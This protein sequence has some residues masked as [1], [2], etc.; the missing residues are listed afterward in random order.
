MNQPFPTVQLSVK[1][2]VIDLRW[3]QPDPRLLPAADMQRATQLALGR[4][5]SESLMY[6]ADAGAGPLLSWLSNRIEQK[7]GRAVSPKEIAVTG[8]NSDALDQIC[9]LETEPGDVVL[10]EDYT[11]HLAA[12]I[13][14]DHR[15]E[16]VPIATDAEGIRVNALQERLVELKQ[17]GRTPR[18]FY[19]IPTFHNPTGRSLSEA[20]RRGLLKVAA[21]EHL[22]IVEDDV[23]RELAY[24]GAAPPS[25]WSLAPDTVLRMGSFAKS[26]SPGLRLG[27]LTGR[28]ELIHRIVSSGLR[29]SGGGVN[30]FA[31]MMVSEFCE[32]G[33]FDR[34]VGRLREAYRAR[35]D[36]LAQAL[37]DNL[38]GGSFSLPG[39]GFFLWVTLPEEMDAVRLRADAEGEGVDFIPGTR[40][41]LEGRGTNIMRLAFTLYEPPELA[42]GV[43]RLA[44]TLE[45]HYTLPVGRA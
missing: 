34:Q 20:R 42:E 26:L 25:L 36:A 43:K 28:G 9:T 21:A 40:F 17:M 30:H 45:R 1:P 38:P 35:R 23:Y 5:G 31:A 2:N 3:G 12:R 33:F 7:E 4:Y 13:M 41:S 44:T 11:Y 24:D 8:G 22:L 16:L 27:W 15:L 39:G 6:G 19:T 18:F 10:V 14:R 32:Q 37:A 29:D